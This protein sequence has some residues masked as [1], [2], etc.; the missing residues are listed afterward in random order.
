M[1]FPIPSVEP[2]ALTAG[3][4]VQWT[5]SLAECPA[6]AGWVLT[7]ELRNA[8]N[9]YS[10]TAAASGDDHAV[11]VTAAVTGVWTPGTYRLAGYA[12]LGAERHEIFRGA[13]EVRANLAIAGATDD[14]SHVKRVLDAIEAVIADRATRDQQ[15]YQIAGRSLQRTPMADLLVLRDRYRAEYER[16]L[17]AARLA[18]GER[19]RRVILTR[20]A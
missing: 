20:F 19:G 16:E 3:D 8:T 15:F 5:R 7:Y 4:T 10:F 1:T 6:S 2:T 12:T 17:A 11:V 18:R 9:A 13:V 14:R